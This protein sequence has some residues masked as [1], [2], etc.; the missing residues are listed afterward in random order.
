MVAETLKLDSQLHEGLQNMA[1][2]L[3]IDSIEATNAANSGHPTSCSSM[4]EIMSVLF[5]KE[6]RYKL[7]AP[8]DPASDRIILSKGHAAPILYAAWAEAGLFPVEELK[9]LRQLG[10]DLEGHPTP[11]L[12]F[13]DVATGSLGHGLSVGAGM[14]Y[15]AKYIDKVDFRVYCIIGDGEAAEGSVWEALN[16]ASFYKLDNLVP[17]FDI[18]RLGQSDPTSLGH[19]VDAYKARLESFGLEAIVVDGHNIDALCTAF[20]E[21][22]ANKE[23]P[24]AI[25]AK[26][27]KGMHIPGIENMEGW[28]GK[29]LGDKAQK[30]IEDI[31][32]LI[33]AC[34]YK[35]VPPPPA[36]VIMESLDASKI[37]LTNPPAYKIGQKVATREAYGTAL[38]KLNSDRV[39]AL[40][41]D[42]KNSTFSDKLRKVDK[43][44]HIECFICEQNMVGVG[45]GAG[46]RGRTIPFCSTFACFLT[47][48]FDQL[49][50]GAISQ[51]NLN[52]VGSHAGV[53]IGEDGPSQMGLED[54]AMF[55]AIPEC[56]VF[57]P[58]DAVA[59]ERAVELAAQLPKMCFIRV[60][61]PATPVFYDNGEVFEVGKAK[62]LKK[63]GSD[64]VLVIGCGVT[65]D[66]AMKAAENLAGENVK[67]R[68]MDPFTI[69]PLDV[70][71]IITHARECG[72]RILT[73]EDHYPE[74][75]VGE[76]VASCV[77]ECPDIIVKKLAVP[78]IPRSGQPFEL[79]ETYGIGARAIQDA[80]HNI[81]Q[82]YVMES[83]PG[84]NMY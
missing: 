37:R 63:S 79:L 38:I 24:T 40:D 36:E 83:S 29:A 78:R 55:R 80:V 45:I 60:T 67:V 42:M 27:Y 20:D 8:R 58:S 84:K 34:D 61:R 5:F 2:R 21:A 68:V 22:R 69:K 11:R 54:I 49:R 81:M 39:V 3:R 44:R 50:M 33:T 30:A 10:S 75:G 19:D 17:I 32:K 64:Q 56:T 41:G 73:V 48:A 47:R 70:Q 76:A 15:V 13:V 18:N 51:T 59:T 16:F 35:P 65:L 26:T 72:G 25:V 4:A 53:S 52:L 23:K 57:Y 1:H 12:N 66:E 77:S 71:G 46:C 31:K 14:A 9:K 62:I 43:L 7:S 74:G 82:S 6:M 28:H